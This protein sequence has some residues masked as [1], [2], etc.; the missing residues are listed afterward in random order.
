MNNGNRRSNTG[1]PG[2]ALPAVIILAGAILLFPALAWARETASFYGVGLDASF[3]FI[4]LPAR[5]LALLG[6]TLMFFQFLLSAR[7]PPVERHFKRSAM[8]KT[9]RSLGKIAYIMVLLH[10]LGMIAFDIVAAGEVYWYRENIAGLIALVLLTLAVLAA[11][12]FKPLRLSLGQWRAIHLFTY[13]VF[14]IVI[15][16]AL[17][18]GSTVN[19]VP[20]LRYLLYFFL[21][22]YCLVVIHRLYRRL[23]GKK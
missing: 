6:L 16:H 5:L 20:S 3:L 14:P 22:G 10:G 8:L 1:R 18:L 17:M 7:F 12:F 15:W 13:L 19:A 11:W 9:H 21:A 23:T 2:P 4:Y